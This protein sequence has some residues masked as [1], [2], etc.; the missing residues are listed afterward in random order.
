MW[1]FVFCALTAFINTDRDLCSRDFCVLGIWEILG[2][3]GLGG[4]ELLYLSA[5]VRLCVCVFLPC[6]SHPRGFGGVVF[7]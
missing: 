5:A 2:T 3:W 1:Y 4:F 7:A 6:T